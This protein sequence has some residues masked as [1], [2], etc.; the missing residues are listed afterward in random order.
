MYGIFSLFKLF[1]NDN[2][3]QVCSNQFSESRKPVKETMGP[4]YQIHLKIHGMHFSLFRLIT[5]NNCMQVCSKLLSE[6]RIHVNLNRGPIHCIHNM[7]IDF[8]FAL[9]LFGLYIYIL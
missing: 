4:I 1:T 9:L 3:M 7:C 5:N 8:Y 2:C 6:S